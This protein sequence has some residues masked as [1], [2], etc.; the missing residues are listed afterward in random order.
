[1]KSRRAASS[2][3]SGLGFRHDI[4]VACIRAGK[5]LDNAGARLA[6]LSLAAY[7]KHTT[8]RLTR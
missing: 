7:G 8:T 5:M 1:M 6:A 3:L 4:G 2:I